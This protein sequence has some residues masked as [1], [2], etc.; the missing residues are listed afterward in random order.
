[1]T[2][3]G[4]FDVAV[5]T[6]GLGAIGLAAISHL[7][8]RSLLRQAT[9]RLA[10]AMS[11]HAHGARTE[12]AAAFAA[13]VGNVCETLATLQHRIPKHHP[14]TGLDTRE[15]FLDAL[16]CGPDGPRALG[17]IVIADF[18]S[19]AAF[20][21]DKADYVLNELAQRLVRMM[22]A[23][24]LLAQVDR[25]SFA[26]LFE[27]GTG[28]N[29]ERELQALCY[30][31]RGRVVAADVEYL[32][33]IRHRHVRVTLPLAKAA[34]VLARALASVHCNSIDASVGHASTGTDIFAL[35]QDLRQAVQKHQFELWYQPVVDARSGTLCSVEALIRWRHPARGMVPPGQFIPVME[36]M[37]LSEE[38][39]HWV[40]D[41]A[42]RDASAWVRAGLEH[43][44]VAVNLS[45]HQLVRPDLDI[46]VERLIAR[47]GLPPAMLELELTE[48]AAAVDT[49]AARKLF[50]KFRARGMTIVID[51][52]GAGYASLSY[53]KRLEFDKLK[54]DREFV[55]NV[56]TDRHAQAICR[57]IIA[58]ARGLDLTVLGEGVERREEY[59]WLRA[60]GCNLFQGYYFAKPLTFDE[61]LSFAAAPGTILEK[62]A[63]GVSAR[64][65]HLGVLAA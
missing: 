44:K 63:S 41:R 8:H 5:L 46:I 32:P 25:A 53:L 6:V 34:S 1:M 7:R 48:T 21:A 49:E 33:Q 64:Q 11:D 38:I 65:P 51:D 9:V 12:P 52:F 61:L 30:A 62:C 56:D 10:S 18:D 13:T 59:V 60:Q 55:T 39:G 43:V 31:L 54:I 20:D 42:A 27:S 45:A 28:E 3:F 57:S 17:I 23:D 22:P 58:L 35:E 2:G 19:L 24:R 16:I 40:L 36:N 37:G 29:V 15:V 50:A 14:V 4:M 26:I 47:H